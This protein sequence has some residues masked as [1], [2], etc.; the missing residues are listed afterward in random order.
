MDW[1]K[2]L[3]LCRSEMASGDGKN[4]Q[5]AVALSQRAPTSNPG[6]VEGREEMPP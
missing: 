6:H 2:H 1:E 5:W 3:A 4:G